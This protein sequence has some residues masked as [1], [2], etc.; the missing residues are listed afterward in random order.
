MMTFLPVI[1]ASLLILGCSLFSY[2]KNH[3]MEKDL[4]VA[5]LRTIL[6]LFLLGHLLSWIFVKSNLGL[7]IL[8]AMIMTFN[9]A[10]HSRSRVRYRHKGLFLDNLMATTFAIWPLAF[11]G[12][13]MMKSDQWLS[14]DIILPLFG[15]LLGNTLTGIATGVDHFSQNLFERKE[16]VLSSLA[17]GATLAEATNPLIRRSLSLAMNPTINSMYT[18]GI[19]SI[20]GM[21]TGQLLAGSLP[22]DAAAIQI[23][24]M[25]LIASGAYLGS[26]MGL[27]FC[28]GKLFN[29]LGQPCF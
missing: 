23:I 19:V 2:S 27:S 28:R 16:D 6:Q 21:M 11:M 22:T 8:V 12:S 20:P 5:S 3:G 26:F 17:L 29:S 25:L 1:L 24:I 13:Y 15:M 18:M 7:T 4:V 14:S 9:A 10:Y